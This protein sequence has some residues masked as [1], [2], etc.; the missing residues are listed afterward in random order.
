MGGGSWGQLEPEWA[1][2]ER[3]PGR[4][5]ILEETRKAERGPRDHGDGTV[6]QDRW[7]QEGVGG[8]GTGGG[9]N[10]VGRQEWVAG[11]RSGSSRGGRGVEKCTEGWMVQGMGGWR[12]TSSE[13]QCRM[14]W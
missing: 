3:A 11:A 12:L 13:G 2:Q 5:E 6:S 14:A 10:R 8:D 1:R 9:W 4:V 7:Q